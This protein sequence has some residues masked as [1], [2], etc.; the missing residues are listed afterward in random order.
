MHLIWGKSTRSLSRHL[1]KHFGLCAKML[2]G[3]YQKR[4][5]SMW[6]FLHET[7]SSLESTDHYRQ[8]TPDLGQRAKW[9]E[10]KNKSK[11]CCCC[12][13]YTTQFFHE[14]AS[15]LH[16]P[17]FLPHMEHQRSAWRSPDG[18]INQRSYLSPQAR[19]IRLAQFSPR[20]IVHSAHFSSFLDK[21]CHSA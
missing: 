21:Y 2:Q 20:R 6:C 7:S 13:F 11:F 8:W 5:K 10:I 15:G 14:T 18:K 1:S 4:K 9:K 16:P 19:R 3:L 17:Q 12:C